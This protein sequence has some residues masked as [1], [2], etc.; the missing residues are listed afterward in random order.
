MK[1]IL[2]AKSKWK[3]LEINVN[4]KITNY[5]RTFVIVKQFFKMVYMYCNVIMILIESNKIE[6]LIE[7]RN[8]LKYSI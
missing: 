5:T 1:N 7:V 4:Y 6:L 3:I 8:I 2:Q